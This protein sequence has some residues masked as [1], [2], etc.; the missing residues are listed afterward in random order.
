MRHVTLI[1]AGAGSGKTYRL[2]EEVFQAVAEGRARADRIMLTTF[3]KK[4][5]AELRGRVTARLIARGQHDEARRIGSALIGTVHSICATLLQSFS[6]EL[7]LAVRQNVLDEEAGRKLFNRAVADGLAADRQAELYRISTILE[8][9][10]WRDTIRALADLVRVNGI[11]PDTLPRWA[12]ESVASLLEGFTENPSGRTRLCEEVERAL[13]ALTSLVTS[14]KD[15][16]KKTQS[17]ISV[18]RKGSRE[19][20]KSRGIVWKVVQQLARLDPAKNA[21]P[22]VKRVRELADLNYTWPEMRA[23]MQLV[24][25]TIFA[26]VQSVLSV[27]E[28]MKRELGAIDYT[29]MECMLLAALDQEAVRTRLASRLDLLMVDEF[30]DTSPIQMAIFLKLTGLARQVIWVGDPKQAIYGFRG[31]DPQLMHAALARIESVGRTDRLERSWRSR[32]EL[33]SFVNAVF[34]EVFLPQGQGREDVALTATRPH[35][36][37]TPALESWVLTKVKLDDGRTKQDVTIDHAQLASEVKRVLEGGHHGVIDRSSGKVRPIEPGDIALLVRANDT[38]AALAEAFRASGI[39][40]EVAVAGLLQEREVIWTRAAMALLLNPSDALA[41]ARLTWLLDVEANAT[42]APADWLT[43]RIQEAQSGDGRLPWPDHP[44]L[45]RIRAAAPEARSLS[46]EQLV[47]LAA[48]L[49]EAVAFSHRLELPRLAMANQERLAHLARH[50]TQ[51]E[52]GFGRPAT[53]SGFLT[54]LDQLSEDGEDRIRPIAANAVQ[55]CTYHAAKGLEWPMVILYQLNKEYEA[56]PFDVRVTTPDAIDLD[57]PLAD[58]GVIYWPYMYGRLGK[59]GSSDFGFLDMVKEKSAY[60]IMARKRQEEEVRLL[61]VAM[62]RA[63]DYLVFAARPGAAQA[64]AVLENDA[65]KPTLSLPQDQATA[66]AGWQVKV[67]SIDRRPYQENTAAT[68]EWITYKTRTVKDA[69][70]VT[71]STLAAPLDGA[72]QAK[73]S[74]PEHYAARIALGK[75]PDMTRVGLAVHAFLAAETNAADAAGKAAMA[76]RILAAYGVETV[77]TPAQVV[78]LAAGF[79]QWVTKRWPG[80][81]LHREVSLQAFFDGVLTEGSADLIV[82][83]ATALVIIDHKLFPGSA[84]EAR[85]RAALYAPQLWAYKRIVEQALGKPVTETGIHMPVGGFYLVVEAA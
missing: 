76:T 80:A 18:L 10:D 13:A 21:Q 9:E 40:C 83:T 4:A 33:V 77:V 54:W 11:S 71:P 63:R 6:F 48:D 14:G 35:E 16:T 29:D 56:A 34:G 41:A 53:T 7:G 39:P 43:R 60:G 72:P 19:L 69:G 46:P 58:R 73:V 37:T 25:S 27:Y 20:A 51:A 81:T 30:Q 74:E 28:R 5:A 22:L 3:T 49:S 50:Y 1:G 66:P 17:A 70:R 23:E 12:D 68:R 24:V 84:A 8:L 42:V 2:A 52:L 55:I 26:A 59:S 38:S 65:G 15:D 57:R 62:T 32:P 44:L 79:H 75:T 31:T 61:Y 36:L 82:E 67:P 47:R 45:C 78:E 85:E 64:L